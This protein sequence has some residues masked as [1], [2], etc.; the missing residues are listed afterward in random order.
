M[1]D[2]TAAPPT[3]PYGGRALPPDVELPGDPLPLRRHLAQMRRE[4]L[5]RE[6]EQER[7]QEQ[8]RG[9]EPP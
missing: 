3:S 2:Q 7:E 1:P 8:A 6:A 5:R 9:G 4:R